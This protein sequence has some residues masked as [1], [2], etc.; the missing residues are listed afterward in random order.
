LRIGVLNNLR[1][2]RSGRRVSRLLEVLRRHPEVAHIETDSSRGLSEALADLTHEPIDLL[3]LNGGDGT[4]QHTLTELLSNEATERL[5]WIAPLRGGSTNMTALDLGMRRDPV[6][7]LE[8][9]IR[10]AEKGRVDELRVNRPVLHVASSRRG[11]AQYGMFFG[12]GTI[13]RAIDLTHRVFPTGRSRGV[14]GASIVTGALI[15]KI[16]A[17]STQGI[18]TPDKIQIVIDERPV[19]QGEFHLAIACSLQRLFMRMN[20]F[21]GHGPGGVRFT[22]IASSE[23]RL[24]RNIPGILCGRP[25]GHVTPENGFTSE[26]ADRVEIRMD[27]GFTVDG[28][29]FAPEADERVTITADRRITFVRA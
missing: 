20:P 10:A 24:G 19:P 27:C 4:L 17:R 16:L 3:I 11:P 8:F 5:P 2:G 18:L 1:A 7:A 23:Q 26:N 6:A 22:S 25:G 13:L 9:L 28:E 14:F 21:W 12:A 29:I 15:A